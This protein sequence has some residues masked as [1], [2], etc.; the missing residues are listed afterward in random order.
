MK[1]GVCFVILIVI[2][3]GVFAQSRDRQDR[4]GS[5]QQ[6]PAITVTGTLSLID[7]RIALENDTAV[8]YV[9][10]LGK[11]IGFVDGL[12]EGA[13]V[14]LEGFG[15]PLHRRNKSEA[16]KE[17][18]LLRVTRLTLDGRSYDLPAPAMASAGPFP[19]HGFPMPG[20]RMM[21]NHN[22]RY[23]RDMPGPWGPQN[24][25]PGRGGWE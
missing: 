5:R 14:T 8:Y 15:R 12:K 22:Q 24:R 9:A 21:M 16:D 2:A 7:G 1:K 17:R 18:Q 25:R 20:H 10:G 23:F 4:D 19:G 13:G 11:L 3:A 6:P